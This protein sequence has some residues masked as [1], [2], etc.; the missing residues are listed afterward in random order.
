MN[1]YFSIRKKI[2][3]YYLSIETEGIGGKV[4]YSL[5]YWLFT[6]SFRFHLVRFWEH[7]DDILACKK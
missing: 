7:R 1:L 3:R 2:I 6:N 4:G 5:S